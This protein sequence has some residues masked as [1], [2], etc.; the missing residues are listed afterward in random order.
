MIFKAHGF[1]STMRYTNHMAAAISNIDKY[2]IGWLNPDQLTLMSLRDRMMKR[3]E[4][5]TLE[6]LIAVEALLRKYG[7]DI[8]VPLPPP[9]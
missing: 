1:K 9:E 5:I 4:S 7:C 8:A 3:P 2:G 6:T